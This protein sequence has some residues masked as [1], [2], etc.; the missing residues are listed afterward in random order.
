MDQGSLHLDGG[1]GAVFVGVPDPR[2][3]PTKGCQRMDTALLFDLDGTLVDT[4]AQHFD[5][6]VE[7]LAGHGIALDE[8]AYQSRIMGHPGHGIAASF[9]PHLSPDEGMRV[10]DHKEQ[11][12]RDRLVDVAP[13]KGTYELLDFAD[14]RGIKYALVTNAPR[15]NALAVLGAIGVTERFAAIVSGADLPHSKPHPLPYLTG[16]EL[17]GAK[18]GRSVAFED[19]RSG[20][21][22]AV[23]AK[24]PLVGITSTLDAA[25]LTRLG[26]QICVRDF[27][28]PAVRELIERQL[29]G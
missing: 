13:L 12:Y 18:A 21:K 17:L 3:K 4:E 19:A 10:M 2:N 26:A 8:A 5:A 23:A 25:T 28:D 22:A 11:I 1:G 7:V 27:A 9:L 14:A 29:A 15:A 6:F 20:A 24:I 16:L